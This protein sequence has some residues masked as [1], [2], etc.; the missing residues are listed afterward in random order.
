MNERSIFPAQTRASLQRH[1]AGTAVA[2]SLLPVKTRQQTGKSGY[3]AVRSRFRS[4]KNSLR[5]AV[6]SS[7]ALASNLCGPPRTLAP[8]G[9][10]FRTISH[11]HS[12]PWRLVLTEYSFRGKATVSHYACHG[13]G[14]QDSRAWEAGIGPSPTSWESAATR[15]GVST[16]I[17]ARDPGYLP[18]DGGRVHV[19]APA[20]DHRSPTSDGRRF[21]RVDTVRSETCAILDACRAWAPSAI[22]RQPPWVPGPAPQAARP[23]CG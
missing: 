14:R 8:R 4:A 13:V 6:P 1:S 22:R 19:G 9:W 10:S 12:M 7:K 18:C 11:P 5:A 17:G 2:P 21:Q 3:P 23:A 16:V 20:D 15:S